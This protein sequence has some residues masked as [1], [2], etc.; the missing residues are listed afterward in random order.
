MRWRISWSENGELLGACQLL[1]L[2]NPKCLN[3]IWTWMIK[4]S[5]NHVNEQTWLLKTKV[6]GRAM[7][8]GGKAFQARPE[9]LRK[10]KRINYNYYFGHCYSSAVITFSSFLEHWVTFYQVC[11]T[12]TWWFDNN[13]SKQ[14][15]FAQSTVNFNFNLKFLSTW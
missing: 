13:Y 8:S 7:Y 4:P 5:C 3:H 10:K 9:V 12:I 2:S 15:R 6:T 11:N 1:I 14:R